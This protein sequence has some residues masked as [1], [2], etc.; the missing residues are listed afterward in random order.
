MRIKPVR[1]LLAP[2]GEVES[3]FYQVAF[4]DVGALRLFV[5]VDVVTFAACVAAILKDDVTTFEGIVS[6]RHLALGV[7]AHHYAAQSGLPWQSVDH[8]SGFLAD[9][10]AAL[11]ALAL[12]PSAI[13]A[14]VGALQHSGWVL[15]LSVA[16]VLPHLGGGL[17]TGFAGL[18]ASQAVVV[19][20]ALAHLLDVPC[21]PAL[22]GPQAF[23]ALNQVHLSG[24]PVQGAVAHAAELHQHWAFYLG[25]VSAQ[26][27]GL[28]GGEHYP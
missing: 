21:L 26:P 1:G 13:L 3:V 23:G 11:L 17:A 14:G 28:L 5:V 16:Y 24:K 8:P 12:H 20:V 4:E 22:D 9:G 19:A 18:S 25:V 27:F 10:F 7:S 2:G 6:V 15:A